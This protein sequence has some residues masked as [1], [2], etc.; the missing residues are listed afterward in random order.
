MALFDIF[1]I[2]S[3][4]DYLSGFMSEEE[5]RKLQ[6]RAGQNALLQS[7]LAMLANSG[8]SRTPVSLGQI[9]GAGGQAGL[10]AY[11]GTL[12]QGAQNVLMQQKLADMKRQRDIQAKQDLF[13]AS[14]GQPNAERQVAIQP[15]TAYQP[16]PAQEGAVAPNFNVQPSPVQYKTEQYFD[17][18]KMMQQA[19]QS[20]A[21]DFKDYLSLVAKDKKDSPFAKIDPKDYTKESLAAYVRTGDITQL[22]P[23]DKTK[24]ENKQKYTGAYGN[25]ALSMFG[26]TEADSL[27][28]QQRTALDAEARRRNLERPPSISINL[29][30]ESERTAGFLTQRLQGGLQQLNQVVSKN[31]KA[32]APNV[33]A[34][35]VKFLTGSDYLKNLTNPVD[36]QRIE[37]AQLE[38]L[39]SAL[40]LGSGAAYTREQLENYRKSYFPQLGD[41]PQTIKDKQKRLETL[42]ES[43]RRKSGRAAPQAGGRTNV[44]IYNQYGV[45]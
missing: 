23:I 15:E 4:A 40:T 38:V 1:G 2:G 12:D 10:Q 41:N 26:T 16:M 17:P 36:R 9:L 11:Q 33:G 31:P 7:G 13:R 44:D 34:E 43:A 8:Y 28:P 19:L 30:S 39:D 5:R 35:A 24:S 20:G 32:A 14:I 45:E 22:T 6:E 27:T 42:L 3:S 25:L 18:D 21:L 37:A 29:P